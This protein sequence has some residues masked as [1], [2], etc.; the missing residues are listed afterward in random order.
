MT[1][2]LRWFAFISQKFGKIKTHFHYVII[3]GM[4]SSNA[5]HIMEIVGQL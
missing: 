4:G 2:L 3:V 1:S 5:F